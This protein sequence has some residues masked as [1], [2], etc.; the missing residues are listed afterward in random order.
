[1]QAPDIGQGGPWADRLIFTAP[2]EA[3]EG[4]LEVFEASMKDGSIT[5]FASVKVQIAAASGTSSTLSI[6]AP[7]AGITTTL[8]LHV[9][10]D[11]G[12]GDEQFDLVLTLSDGS[13]LRQTAQASLGSVVTSIAGT[14]VP[15]TATLQILRTDGTVVEE[16]QVTIVPPDQTQTV[17][18][19]W[20]TP[21]T[22][23]V[24]L[25]ERSVPRT[26]QIASAALEELLWGPTN[27]SDYATS[28]PSTAEIMT[29]SGRTDT[30]GARVRLL[31]LVITDGVATANFSPELQAYSGGAARATAIRKQIES[32]LLQ[33]PS[34]T[35]VVIQVDGQSEGVLEP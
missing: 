12:R 17:R 3:Q 10:F 29:A 21:G 33:F 34:V 25:E 11:G 28:I 32:T 1:V 24:V 26:P 4:T 20:L 8:P 13:T 18:V 7:T 5:S 19:A 27:V 15:G 2:S 16:R 14:G 6:E 23:E 22:E 35:Q 30:W 9:A 31:K